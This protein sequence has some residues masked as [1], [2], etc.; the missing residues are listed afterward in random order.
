MVRRCGT[1]M[2]AGKPNAGKSTLFNMLVSDKRSATSSKADTTKNFR[3]AYSLTKSAQVQYVDTPGYDDKRVHQ[4]IQQA[5][6]VLLVITFQNWTEADEKFSEVCREYRVPTV[7]I[8]NKVDSSKNWVDQEAFSR[9]LTD[10]YAFVDALHVSAK[11]GHHLNLIGKVIK[12][13]LK[14]SNVI[15]PEVTVSLE[16]RVK[17]VIYEKVFRLLH[18]EIPHQI[19]VEVQIIDEVIWGF[20]TFRK[21]SHKKIILGSKGRNIAA[22]TDQCAADLKRVLK[23]DTPFKLHVR[24]SKSQNMKI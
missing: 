21:K 19:N 12:R 6:V 15:V 8:I 17:E 3:Y 14:R 18:R 7:L 23:V 1:I 5:D 22:L 9:A 16:E 2:I 20:I 11:H 10:K 4:I 13:Y 24:R